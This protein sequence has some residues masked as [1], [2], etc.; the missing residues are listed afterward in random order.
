MASCTSNF[1]SSTIDC[2]TVTGATFNTNSGK[3]EALITTRCSGSSCHSAGGREAGRFLAIDNYNSV[4]PFLTQ[5]ANSVLR[6]N[7]PQGSS[8]STT[9]LAQW[10]C[11]KDAGFPQ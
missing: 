4:K 10:Q 7:M 2:S 3:L 1:N 11:W 9:E 5:G 8:L 6:G